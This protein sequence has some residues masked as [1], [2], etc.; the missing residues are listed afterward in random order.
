MGPQLLGAVS[1]TPGGDFPLLFKILDTAEHLSIQVHPDQTCAALN[2]QW[3][4]KTESWYVID[5][6]PGAVIFKGFRPGVDMEMVRASVGTPSLAGLLH[7]IP[8]RQGDF[9]HIPAGMVH[10]LGAGVTVAEVQTPSDTTFRLYDWTQEYE[11]PAR[12]LQIEHGLQAL[13]LDPPADLSYDPMAGD[14]TRLLVETP[15]YWLREHRTTDRPIALQVVPELRIL[16]VVQGSVQVATVGEPP[17]DLS[18]GGTVMVPAEIATSTRVDAIGT[19][20]LLEIG[21]R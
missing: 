2:P 8:V 6:K 4:A 11:R 1:P 16:A 20:V 5:A 3:Q 12:R 9:H 7:E 21:L 14:G 13:S 15:Y 10:A 18:S 19:S 17:M